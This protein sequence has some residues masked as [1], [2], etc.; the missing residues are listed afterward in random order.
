MGDVAKDP[1]KEGPAARHPFFKACQKNSQ[2][3]IQL[4]M[5]FMEEPSQLVLCEPNSTEPNLFHH[6]ETT[7]RVGRLSENAAIML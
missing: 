3:V 5:W 7:C 1:G 6:G 4:C 2:T